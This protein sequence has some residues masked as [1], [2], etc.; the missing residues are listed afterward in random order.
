MG[1]SRGVPQNGRFIREKSYI[2]IKMDDL[3][4]PPFMETPVWEILELAMEV[5]SWD[6]QGTKLNGW[7][8]I[9]MNT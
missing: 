4:V 8:S 6:N 1:V 7:F 5:Y 9:D 2:K 3:G